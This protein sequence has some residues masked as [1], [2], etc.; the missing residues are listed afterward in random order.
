MNGKLIQFD[1]NNQGV[2]ALRQ[3]TYDGPVR[4]DVSR[5]GQ[6]DTD[7]SI[8]AGDMV[9]LMNWWRYATGHHLPIFP[10]NA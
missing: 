1:V 7:F 4:V 5:G 9:M 10:D 3:E 2:M 6:T 8:P